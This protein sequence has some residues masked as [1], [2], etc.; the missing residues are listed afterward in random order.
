MITIIGTVRDMT[1]KMMVAGHDRS[2]L[3]LPIARG[4][5]HATAILIRGR[6]DLT[7]AALQEIFRRVA[8]EP[9]IFE[10]IPLADIRDLQTWP[11]I[12]A[13]WVG[14]LLAA[15]AFGLGMS[16]LY[17]VLA[18]A[19]SDRQKEI[20][21]RLALGASPRNVVALVL[22]QG[23]KLAG[24]GAAIGLVLALGGLGTLASVIHLRNVNVLDAGAFAIGLVLVVAATIA[25]TAQPALRA[26][27][28]SPSET[29]RTDA[30]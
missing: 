9:Q 21:I 26:S 5:E 19:L 18:Y 29:L 25:A 4:N 27:R 20:G 22:R 12:A 6:G 14:A 3:Y 17:G 1:T 11:L 2:H 16:G 10:A 13:S 24:I 15:I 28:V 23:G 30:P 7:P 8:P